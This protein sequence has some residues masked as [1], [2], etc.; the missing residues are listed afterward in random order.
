[1]QRPLPKGFLHKSKP[2]RHRIACYQDWSKDDARMFAD[3]GY[4]PWC[5]AAGWANWELLF[6]R[7]AESQG[8]KLGFATSADLD[9]DPNLLSGY[10][11][12]LSVG[13]DEYWSAS[14]RD[15]VEG[16]VD[17][18]GN[19]AFFSGNTSFWQARFED[20][21]TRLVCFKNAMEDDPVFDSK[22]APTWSTMW[23]DPLVTR[24]ENA[25]T[26]V[27]F[28]RGGYAH[29]PNAPRGTG[30][31]RFWQ[32]D[33]WAFASLSVEPGARWGLKRWWSV[34]NVTAANSWSAM[35]CR[36]PPVTTAHRRLSKCWRPPVRVCGK[37]KMRWAACMQ[38]T[39]VN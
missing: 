39:L 24:P 19:A 26:G 22:S 20:D 21:H 32:T 18:G 1:M 8:L 5:M 9:G 11:V 33:H 17:N 3:A 12:Y 35:A 13:H 14:M 30:G 6:V 28:T 2:A 31:Y 7:W 25:M 27:S 16:H 38:A 36:L 29:M 4:S 34:T 15:N 10:P 23:S 37:P